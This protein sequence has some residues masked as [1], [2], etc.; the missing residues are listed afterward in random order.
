MLV[1]DTDKLTLADVTRKKDVAIVSYC[2]CIPTLFLCSRVLIRIFVTRSG[3][4]TPAIICSLLIVYSVSTMTLTQY[5]WTKV[6]H[7]LA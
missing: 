1:T 3:L 4:K 7:D 5:N 2:T 6:A